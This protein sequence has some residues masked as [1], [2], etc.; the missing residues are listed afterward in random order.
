[1]GGRHHSGT[2]MEISRIWWTFLILD[3]SCLIIYLILY[4]KKINTAIDLN[5]AN[6]N[7]RRNTSVVIT[8]DTSDV[9]DAC[10]NNSLASLSDLSMTSSGWQEVK[11]QQDILVY[12]AF[13]D[14]RLPKPS[15]MILGLKSESY[16]QSI[17]CLLWYEEEQSAV[18]T[19]ARYRHV[20][21]NKPVR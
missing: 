11:G 7:V 2:K 18:I 3:T 16:K 12:S 1:M 8:E 20:K 19:K 9:R 10:W 5:S 13:W 17:W 6:V 14:A 21:I 15:V 4:N